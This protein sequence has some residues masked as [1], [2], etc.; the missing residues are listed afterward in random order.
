MS[1]PI[2][3]SEKRVMEALW[4]SSPLTSQQ[5]VERLSHQDWNDKTVKTF[6]NRLVNK[7]ALSFTRQGRAYLYSPIVGR[8]EFLAAESAGFLQRVFEGD[9]KELLTTFVANKQLSEKE[10]NHLRELLDE[11]AQS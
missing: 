8:D 1:K 4:Q 6:L 5:V 10:L 7:G 9:M 3:E 2:S 11:E